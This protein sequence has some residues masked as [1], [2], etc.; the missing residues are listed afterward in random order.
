MFDE[1]R[2]VRRPPKGSLTRLGVHHLR[3]QLFFFQR[4]KFGNRGTSFAW[5]LLITWKCLLTRDIRRCSMNK[6]INDISFFVKS[7]ETWKSVLPID[8]GTWDYFIEII[9]YFVLFCY[10]LS[11]LLYIISTFL[12]EDSHG[13][14]WKEGKRNSVYLDTSCTI[15]LKYSVLQYLQCRSNWGSKWEFNTYYGPLNQARKNNETCLLVSI[16]SEQI[17]LEFSSSS[18]KIAG[19]K[20][21]KWRV[22]RSHE[23][24]GDSEKKDVE[25]PYFGEVK[26]LKMSRNL[27][28][29][30]R[31]KSKRN[32][33]RREET[34][35]FFGRV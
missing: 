32:K 12:H 30:V 21:I 3:G 11:G 19:G 22:T 17:R 27:L 1:Q 29:R 23:K 26:V 35:V 33:K 18:L 28:A 15:Y 14:E 24:R 10:I 2:P 25:E 34:G 7:V 8:L 16:G 13:I 20:F 4:N 5:T 9:F 31:N 6:L